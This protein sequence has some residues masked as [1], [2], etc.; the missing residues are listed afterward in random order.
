VLAKHS[1]FFL[2]LDAIRMVYLWASGLQP[3]EG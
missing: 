3:P 2:M 1:K